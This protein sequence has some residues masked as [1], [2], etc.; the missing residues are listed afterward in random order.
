MKHLNKFNEMNTELQNEGIG[1]KIKA[2]ILG[3]AM[4]LTSC[5]QGKVNG[6]SSETYEGDL[7]V[8]KIE[9][10]GGKYN[11]FYVHGSDDNGK[12]IT[13][14]TNQL[15]FNVGDSIHVDFKSEEA[16]QLNDKDNKSEIDNFR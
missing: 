14:S 11:F 3:A 7:L 2:G 15:T 13:F 8:K 9:I 12:D 5:N 6:A 4:A 1:N 16:Y 10:G